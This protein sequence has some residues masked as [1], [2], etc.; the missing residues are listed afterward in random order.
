MNTS[1]VSLSLTLITILLVGVSANE[2][3]FAAGGRYGGGHGGG[4]HGGGHGGGGWHGGGRVGIYLGVPFG[5]GYGYSPYSYYRAAPYY[6]APYYY[7]PAPAYYPPVQTAP[8]I[9]TERSDS[10]QIST[11]KVSANSASA[12]QGSWWYYCADAKA[13][14]PYVN[15]CPG[16]WLRV[17]PQPPPDSGSQP[18]LNS[19]PAP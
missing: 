4:W 9:Y 12:T 3:A 5:L 1:K 19:S 2:T 11:Q 7:S 16:G 18:V 6:G 15:Q 8:V 10:S 13:Y 14:Y 17:V